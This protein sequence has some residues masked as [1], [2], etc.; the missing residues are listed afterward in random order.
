MD[1]VQITLQV[2]NF[3]TFQKYEKRVEKDREGE[4]T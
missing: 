1:A 2:L 4:E 3:N